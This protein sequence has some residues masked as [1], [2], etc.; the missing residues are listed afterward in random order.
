M[1]DLPVFSYFIH[2]FTMKVHNTHWTC[3]HF[4]TLCK[5]I[6]LSHC[7]GQRM[8]SRQWRRGW[9]ATGTI[10][11]WCWPWRWVRSLTRVELLHTGGLMVWWLGWSTPSWGVLGSIPYVHSPNCR[12]L[13]DALNTLPAPSWHV[14]KIAVGC[15][16]Y[17]FGWMTKIVKRYIRLDWTLC[18][19]SWRRVWRTA[20][21][22]STP[23]SPAGTS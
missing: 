3:Y 12:H 6:V 14:S 7:A 9:M 15:F 22:A 23:S 8:P 11:K 16:G 10:G 5:G 20:A 19:R 21:I 2:L 13:P 18:S 17:T 1:L 4:S